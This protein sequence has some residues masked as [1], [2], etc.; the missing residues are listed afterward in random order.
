MSGEALC[1]RKWRTLE[2]RAR[3]GHTRGDPDRARPMTSPRTPFFCVVNVRVQ[4]VAE[5]IEAT[6]AVERQ[7]RRAPTKS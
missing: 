1:S 3:T 7:R 5:R 4:N 2:I 6:D